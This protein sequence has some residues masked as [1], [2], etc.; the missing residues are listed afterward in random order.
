MSAGMSA[1]FQTDFPGS[2]IACATTVSK[3]IELIEAQRDEPF[4]LI[5]L[6]LV[7]PDANGIAVLKHLQTIE[8]GASAL[9]IVISGVND[10]ETI[11][12]CKKLGARGYICKTEDFT[13]FA[14]AVRA[15]LDG[16]EYFHV[17]ARNTQ[18]HFLDIAD[19]LTNRQRDVLDL[20]LAGY[21]N[22]KIACELDLNYGTVKNY[23]HELLNV[24]SVN[25]RL[26]IATKANLSG[27]VPKRSRAEECTDKE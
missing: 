17:G 27:Y 5:L 13:L 2:V 8:R 22:K 14:N 20:V 15:V 16:G 6:D 3:A 24:F 4:D 23:I 19:R 26:E 11:G 21:S 10:N 7:L 12:L 1:F 9:C 18:G 25:T